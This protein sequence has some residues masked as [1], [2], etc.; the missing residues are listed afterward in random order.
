M[1][2]AVEL[3][4]E[5]PNEAGIEMLVL[6]WEVGMGLGLCWKLVAIG[7][8]RPGAESDGKMESVA[9]KIFRPLFLLLGVPE[10]LGSLW[11]VRM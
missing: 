2:L 8:E 3:L 5:L 11:A 4:K 6:G 7:V 10:A 9:R 1:R